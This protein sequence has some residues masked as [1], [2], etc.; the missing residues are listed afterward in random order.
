MREVEVAERYAEALYSLAQDEGILD[1]V[2]QD[3]ALLRELWNSLP[4]LARFLEHPLVPAKSKEEFFDHALA[5][6]LHPY[7]LNFLKLLARKKRLDYLPLI[8]RAY[9][10]VAE[11]EGRLVSVL[12]RAALPL[13]EEEFARLRETLEKALGKPVVLE[14]EEVPELIAGAEI[15]LL[16][17]RYD[18]SLSG[19][20][21]ALAAELKG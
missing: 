7:T 9:L 16:G 12:V 1:R 5:D 21:Q 3:L 6:T 14:V 2:G 15:R 13:V 4:E 20:L 18:L 8:Q 17:R 10:K 19:R 11:K